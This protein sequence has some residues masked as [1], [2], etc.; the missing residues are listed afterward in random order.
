[1]AQRRM[2]SLLVIDTDH[3][4]DMPASAQALYFHLGMHGDDDGFVSSPKKITRAA[5]CCD[6]D[7]QILASQGYI[8]PFKSGVVVITDWRLHN[9]LKNDRY[10]KTIFQSEK[11]AL[12]IDETG[13]YLLTPSPASPGSKL[14][15]TRNQSIT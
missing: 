9:T 4:M 10:R 8:I 11:A 2:F 14:E 3:F 6:N 1:M 15:P 5:G 13:R 12:T 7:L